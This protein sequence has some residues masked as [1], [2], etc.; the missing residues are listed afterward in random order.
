M[1]LH[2]RGEK[3]GAP[4]FLTGGFNHILKCLIGNFISKTNPENPTNNGNMLLEAIFFLDSTMSLCEKII[5]SV[6]F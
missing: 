1:L 4:W 2:L 3:L 6:I 5:Y